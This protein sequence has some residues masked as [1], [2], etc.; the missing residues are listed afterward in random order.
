M[1]ITKI[2]TIWKLKGKKVHIRT[3]HSGQLVEHSIRIR[4]SE[5]LGI[6]L[7]ATFDSLEMAQK[8]A[9]K[10]EKA[11]KINKDRWNME[12]YPKKEFLQDF[13]D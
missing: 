3:F 11:G 6:V 2:P 5:K 10:I 13:S 4:W 8:I 9:E 1:T 12:F 7:I